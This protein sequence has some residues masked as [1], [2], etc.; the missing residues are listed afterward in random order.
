MISTTNPVQGL[1]YIN[2]G[3]ES[4]RWNFPLADG[5]SLSNPGGIGR[6][7]TISYSFQS[8]MPGYAWDVDLIQ[9]PVTQ[10]SPA[11]Q[12]ATQAALAHI[13]SLANITFVKAPAGTEGQ[14]VFRHS[15]Q[16]TTS[17]FA[18]S[19]AFR[20]YEMN[21]KVDG[22][23]TA[24][25]YAGDIWIDNIDLYSGAELQPGGRGYL[26][27]LHEIGHALGL[28]HSFD[29]SSPYTTA[30]DP[31]YVMRGSLDNEAHTVM[32]YTGAPRT[33]LTVAGNP[34]Y[35][36]AGTMMPLD[37]EALQYLY[38]RNTATE[39]GATTYRWDTNAEILETIWDGGGTDTIDASNQVFKNV[40][41]LT[42]GQYSSIGLRQTDAQ[43]K[44][45]LGISSGYSGYLGD[46]YNGEN[47]VAIAKGVLIE[48]AKGGR[49]GDAIFGNSAA[50]R[51]YGNGGNDSLSGGAGNDILSGG[52]GNDRMVGGAGSDWYYVAQAAD[53]V[54]EA[55]NGGT[56]LVLSSLATYTLGANVENGRINTSAAANLTGNALD[57]LVYAG[58][59]D[60]VLA[61]ADGL[62]TVSYAYAGA[63]VRLSLG[64]T[65]AQATGGSG[66]DRLTGFEHLTG[67]AHADQLTGSRGA[68]NLSGL[69][70]ND[71]LRGSL[72]ADRLTGGAGNDTFHYNTVSESGPGSSTRDVI[73]D[74]ARGQDKINLHALDAKALSPA[75]DAFTFIG[76]GAFSATDA[77]GQ[78]RFAGGVLYGSTDADTAAEF[79]IALTGVTALTDSDIVL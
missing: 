42:A 5:T 65:A 78:L 46:L 29:D 30:D 44:Q 2:N 58:A 27:L 41:R 51:L 6:P 8:D 45:G 62:D 70:G 68:N 26:V 12:A 52:N 72:G 38:G 11:Y 36:S 37:I 57:N 22:P 76:S 69:A 75:N 18:F 9:G 31:T 63:G 40:I 60:N 54:V 66:T 1:L 74:F 71:V 23:V 53:A 47:N 59:G 79:S 10:F 77:S 67:S 24:Y 49:A 73:T 64:S 32:S 50:N 20:Y 19:P 14:M 28:Q 48:N 39:R 21:G 34:S 56:D 4:A 13:A 15:Y 25:D 3:Y 17:G 43:I 33:Q 61:G 16:Q 7:V 55:T 35:L